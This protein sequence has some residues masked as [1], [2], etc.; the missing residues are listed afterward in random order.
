MPSIITHWAGAPKRPEYVAMTNPFKGGG[1]K[2]PR[3]GILPDY[4]YGGKGVLV[5]AVTANGPAAEAGMKKGDVIISIAGKMIGNVDGYTA[6][7]AQQKAGVAIEVRIMRDNR[8][9]ELKVTP[10]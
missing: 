8:E 3:L 10:K 1:P 2:G 7:L 6:L 9:M 5:E 4:T